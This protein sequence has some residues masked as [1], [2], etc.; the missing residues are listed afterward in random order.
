[1]M[2]GG[3]VFIIKNEKK[4][5]KYKRRCHTYVCS[6]LRSPQHILEFFFNVIVSSARAGERRTLRILIN[7]R[8]IS[9]EFPILK[10]S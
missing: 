8:T 6:K 1:M 3:G 4:K 7:D 5:M 2:E 10:T 9:Y